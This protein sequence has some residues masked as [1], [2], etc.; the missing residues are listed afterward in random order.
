MKQNYLDMT[1]L[2]N[3]FILAGGE[4]G[5]WGDVAIHHRNGIRL[6][7]LIGDVQLN[8][9]N[10]VGVHFPTN[11]FKAWCFLSYSLI[12]LHHEQLVKPRLG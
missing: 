4:P 12:L 2:P 1:N 11:V 5:L 7:I 8:L 3:F 6:L 9:G 10:V